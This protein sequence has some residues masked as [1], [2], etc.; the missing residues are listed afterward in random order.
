MTDKSMQIFTVPDLKLLSVVEGMN[1]LQPVLSAE[2][3]RRSNTREPLK[4]VIVADLGD[5]SRTSPYLIVRITALFSIFLNAKLGN[6]RYGQIM[7]T[8]SFTSQF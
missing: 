7:M 2:P 1:C 4:E 5:L 8:W 6:F 3:P